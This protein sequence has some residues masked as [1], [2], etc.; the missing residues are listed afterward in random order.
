MVEALEEFRLIKKSAGGKGTLRQMRG[1]DAEADEPPPEVDEQWAKDAASELGTTPETLLAAI[2]KVGRANARPSG[3]VSSL[4][5][6]LIDDRQDSNS[7]GNSN[8]NSNNVALEQQLEIRACAPRRAGATI[9]ERSVTSARIARRLIAEKPD[10]RPQ[11]ECWRVQTR[12]AFPSLEADF[13]LRARNVAA[14]VSSPRSQLQPRVDLL[15]WLIAMP[16]S[17]TR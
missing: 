7:N 4:E 2:G 9:A 13:V 3:L 14:C 17:T 12:M 5:E 6:L 15:R 11:R 10:R 1:Y 16:T 8:N